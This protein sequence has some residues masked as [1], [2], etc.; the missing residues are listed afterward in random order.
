LNVTFSDGTKVMV[1]GVIGDSTNFFAISH[2]TDP[3][4]GILI[5]Y[6]SSTHSYKAFLLLSP[7]K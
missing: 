1:G 3:K 2:H 4:A 5:E 7:S 6:I